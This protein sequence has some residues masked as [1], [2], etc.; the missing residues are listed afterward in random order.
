MLRSAVMRRTG[1]PS[2]VVKSS[3]S[4]FR[5]KS[6][7]KRCMAFRR[8]NEIGMDPLLSALAVQSDEQVVQV[9]I[10]HAGCEC[11]GDA[12]AGVQEQEGE[13]M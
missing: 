6:A 3:E 11:L 4:G 12:A 9:H 2:S 10:Q 5:L 7:M 1:T 13:Q 8:A